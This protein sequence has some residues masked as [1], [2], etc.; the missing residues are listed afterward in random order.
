MTFKKG[1]KDVDIDASS[2]DIIFENHAPKKATSLLNPIL[3]GTTRK[4]PNYFVKRNK[5][6]FYYEYLYVIEY[7]K[8]GTEH[9][10]LNEKK[11]TVNAG[12]LY[13]FNRCTI[14]YYYSDKDDPVE[15]KWINI[16]GRFMD[17]LMYSFNI[18]DPVFILPLDAESYL[19]RIHHELTCFNHVD[20]NQT[21]ANIMHILVDLF[22]A[23]R[24]KQLSE[25]NSGKKLNIQCIADYISQN[26][27][28]DTL[29]IQ[30]ISTTFFISERTLHRMFVSEFGISPVQFIT[31]KKMEYACYLLMTTNNSI[32]HISNVLNF[33]NGEYF[34]QVFTRFYGKSPSAYRKNILSKRQENDS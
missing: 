3:A 26:I 33:S 6:D 12:D 13:I 8:A 24:A 22:M 29:N 28:S 2:D 9:I 16:S 23:I 20:P 5:I 18:S 21:Y 31:Q 4:D 30:N 32:E 14:P 25:K 1:R 11:Y 17:S 15:K 7:V 19:D 10:H 34:R 27:T